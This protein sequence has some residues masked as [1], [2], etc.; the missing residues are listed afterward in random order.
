MSFYVQLIRNQ[1]RQISDP[2]VL[3]S[4]TDSDQAVAT[5]ALQCLRAFDMDPTSQVF[6]APLLF[7]SHWCPLA[8]HASAASKTLLISQDLEKHIQPL[9]TEVIGTGEIDFG[10]FLMASD[11]AADCGFQTVSW[12]FA[13]AI[14][15]VHPRAITPVQADQ[16]RIP[17]ALHIS[18]HQHAMT[19]DLRLGGTMQ[20]DQL[21]LQAVLKQHEAHQDRLATCASSLIQQEGAEAIPKALGSS[22]PWEDLKTLATQ[23]SPPMRIVLASEIDAAVKARLA[24]GKPVVTKANKKQATTNPKPQVIPIADQIRLPD[25]IFAQQ[26]GQ[27]L[28]SILLHRVEAHAMQHQ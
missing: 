1:G 28:P 17:F 23:A 16:W 13:H 2:I 19:E 12:F 10:S 6:I 20:P 21:L 5:W 8:L 3:D 11:F 7:L 14:G 4:P 18:R 15:T 9:V 25:A 26:D 27:K 22:Q 24:I